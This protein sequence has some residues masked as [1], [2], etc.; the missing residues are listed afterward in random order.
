M[1]TIRKKIDDIIK[2]SKSN[3]EKNYLFFVKKI[4]EL[5][6]EQP[7]SWFNFC[8]CLLR[9]CIVLPIECDGQENA[10]RILIP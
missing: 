5:A 3:Y 6:K 8:L 2:K 4:D 10:L 7:T 9:D 1:N